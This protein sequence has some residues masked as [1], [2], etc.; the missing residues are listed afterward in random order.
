M[1]TDFLDKK[2]ETVSQFL[3]QPNR[4]KQLQ[5]VLPKV[6]I[7]RDRMLKL[8]FSALNQ[9]PK[10]LECTPMSLYN[11]MIQSASLGLE[12]NTPLGH[13]YLVPFKGRVQLIVGYKGYISLAA[14]TGSISKISAHIVQDGDI[15]EY[16]Y[17]TDEFLRH[18]PR[19]IGKATHA[20][21]IAWLKGG[22]PQFEV[23]TLA[24]IESART[25]SASSASG[26]WVT[27]WEMMARKT[28]I[29]KLFH[30]L[31]LSAEAARAV[32]IDERNEA[33]DEAGAMAAIDIDGFEVEEEKKSIVVPDSLQGKAE[34]AQES[35][36]GQ[37]EKSKLEPT[38][39]T[40]TEPPKQEPPKTN[41]NGT[42]GNDEKTRAN[43]RKLIIDKLSTHF[44]GDVILIND[45]LRTSF[46][47]H[48]IAPDMDNLTEFSAA[49]LRDIYAK[50]KTLTT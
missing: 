34:K 31:P 18:V 27:D 4:Q 39:Q 10:L 20:Y 33:D 44:G 19:G 22:E 40:Q 8:V 24:E 48:E 3:M 28:P 13:A 35:K 15:F 30:Y 37:P 42:N 45:F 11:S 16:E 49:H 25:R 23:M 9:T 1:A 14:R 47:G 29:R 36:T 5:A 2:K 12:P 7:T 17:G 38:P 26:P 6:G 43:G 50:V 41:D 21:A 32:S 46:P